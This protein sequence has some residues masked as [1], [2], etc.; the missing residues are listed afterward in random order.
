LQQNLHID[1]SLDTLFYISELGRGSRPAALERRKKDI[2]T[3]RLKRIQN[4]KMARKATERHKPSTAP[5]AEQN[6]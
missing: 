6:I 2:F 1:C 4:S 3:G 5:D